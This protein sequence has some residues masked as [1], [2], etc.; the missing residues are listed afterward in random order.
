MGSRGVLQAPFTANSLFEFI[1]KGEDIAA[2][3]DINRF[4][5]YILDK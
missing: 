3:I 5:R 1:E 4:K 2:E